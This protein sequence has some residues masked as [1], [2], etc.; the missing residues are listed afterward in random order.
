MSQ[1]FLQALENS[2][3]LHSGLATDETALPVFSGGWWGPGL[4]GEG[5][6]MPTTQEAGHHATRIGLLSTPTAGLSHKP[7]ASG[8]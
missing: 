6:P 4:L 1:T 8:Q 3:D 7:T 5:Q 2:E